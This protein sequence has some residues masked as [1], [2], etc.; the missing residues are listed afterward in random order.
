VG[1]PRGNCGGLIGSGIL[2]G[3]E[4]NQEEW[5]VLGLGGLERQA[6]AAGEGAMEQDQG[7]VGVADVPFGADRIGAG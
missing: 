5:A 4:L 1:K 6:R 3:V 2:W 7:A